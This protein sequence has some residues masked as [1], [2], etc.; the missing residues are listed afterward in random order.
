MKKANTLRPNS[1][2]EVD[3]VYVLENLNNF[4]VVFQ[5]VNEVPC[6]IQV[7]SEAGGVVFWDFVDFVGFTADLT[8]LHCEF[9]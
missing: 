8:E 6:L 7:I 4:S 3:G 2:V 5:F 1:F 9:E